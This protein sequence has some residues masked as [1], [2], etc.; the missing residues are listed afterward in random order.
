[1]ISFAEQYSSYVGSGGVYRPTASCSEVSNRYPS[2]HG[3]VFLLALGFGTGSQIHAVAV[4]PVFTSGGTELELYDLEGRSEQT[5]LPKTQV[6]LAKAYLGASVSDLAAALNVQRPTIYQWMSGDSAPRKGNLER[7]RSVY[8]VAEEWH[9]LNP[10]PLGKLLH[11][12][13]SEGKTLIQQLSD[14]EIDRGSVSKSLV[15]LNEAIQKE[16][17]VGRQPSSIAKRLSRLGFN[18]LEP[19][20]YSTTIA[21]SSGV[22]T[23]NKE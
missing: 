21:R 16:A 18:P 11:M 7:L 6:R 20:E 5:P 13:L 15:G 10:V 12:P 3:A 14:P 22:L 1:M 9:K 23:D 2:I 4:K 19:S 8:E 17:E